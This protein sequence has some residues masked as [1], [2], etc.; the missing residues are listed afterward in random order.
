MRDLVSHGRPCSPLICGISSP[1]RMFV[2]PS[3]YSVVWTFF[4]LTAT[5]LPH[6]LGGEA[7][8]ATVKCPVIRVVNAQSDVGE[9][10][11]G[12]RVV[13]S[14]ELTNAGQESLLIQ[15][16]RACCGCMASLDGP[17]AVSPGGQTKVKASLWTRGRR[18]RL[19]RTVKVRSNDLKQP[20]I[21]LTLSCTVVVGPAPRIEVQPSQWDIGLLS[22]GQKVTRELALTNVGQ[23]PLKVT[24]LRPTAGASFTSLSAEEIE[25]S[26]T[27]RAL[28]TVGAPREPGF[29][30][31]YPGFDT[32]DP[33]NPVFRIPI[34]GYVEPAAGP[35][36]R[37]RPD[38]LDFGIVR[39]GE[40]VKERLEIAN[41]GTAPLEVGLVEGSSFP[42]GITVCP[43]KP[44][45]IPPGE[46]A[47]LYIQIRSTGLSQTIKALIPL[48]TND[49]A[50][51][52]GTITVT[53][54]VKGH[55]TVERK[56]PADSD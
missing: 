8:D 22:S 12:E 40:L 28:V 39:P 42:P 4:L 25:P 32:N 52:Y 16:V 33:N 18:G 11:Q 47:E 46:S 53:G 51:K 19:V 29:F 2:A 27:A 38:R 17:K 41:R 5:H 34:K 49:P 9:V 36:L 20:E 31:K 15:E 48:R 3:K 37:V 26:G 50:R 55:G 44:S 13:H 1:R 23:R 6:A 56:R 43:P 14:F 30:E 45:V 21:E 24:K 7:R 10:Q 54:Y 35:L